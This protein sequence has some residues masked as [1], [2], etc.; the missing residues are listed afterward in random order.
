MSSPYPPQGD[1]NGQQPGQPDPY[2]GSYSYELPGQPAQ[3]PPA[4][5]PSGYPQP[6]PSG[7]TDPYNSQQGDPYA[8][9]Q[10][11]P[12]AQKHDP[13]AQP[14]PPAYQQ[15]VYQPVPV[16]VPMAAYSS[17]GYVDP[18]TGRQYS[19]KSKT[20]AGLLQI[21]LGGFGVGR[22]YT[23]HIGIAI[24]Q[25]AVTVTLGC[26]GFFLVLPWCGM[27]LWGLIDGIVILSS[28]TAT[29]SEGRL[30]RS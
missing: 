29:D 19:E 3:G 9:P 18:L 20:T 22:F 12:Y 25:L 5:Q 1:P 2:T 8:Q 21:F 23:G 28:S 24:A 11:D 4:P 26:L 6:Q 15:P 14:Y 30:L 17:G 27:G 13:Y 7:Y 16:A 10:A